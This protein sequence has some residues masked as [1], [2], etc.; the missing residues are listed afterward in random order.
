A[1]N[2]EKSGE[3]SA[4]SYRLSQLADGSYTATV[5]AV[6]EEGESDPATVAFTV[7]LSGIEELEAEGVKVVDGGVESAS[8][9][10]V[11]TLD[12]RTVATGSRGFLPLEGGIYL[13]RTP[14][15]TLKVLVK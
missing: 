6:Y 13:L 9:I 8:A 10:D 3:T 5:T 11:Y 12:G 14:R 2:G 4:T 1:L 15:A 7:E